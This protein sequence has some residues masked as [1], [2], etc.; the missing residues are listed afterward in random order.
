MPEFHYRLPK[1]AGG[2]RPGSHP[3]SSFGAGQAFAMHARLFEI[4]GTAA[5]EQ[6]AAMHL[7]VQGFH[8]SAKRKLCRYLQVV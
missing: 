4:V 5:P 6:N 2:A 8:T 3:G 1:R 7:G